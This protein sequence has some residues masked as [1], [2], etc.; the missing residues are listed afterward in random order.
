MQKP[1]VS[2]VPSAV[3]EPW[4]DTCRKTLHTHLAAVQHRLEG[5]ISQHQLDSGA[6]HKLRVATRRARTV[7]YIARCCLPSSVRKRLD[8]RLRA[9]AEIAGTVRDWDV[10]LSQL[11]H[12]PENRSLDFIAGYTAAARASALRHLLQSRP[13]DPDRVLR[14]IR[15]TF[16][17][18]QVPD[19]WQKI[20]VPDQAAEV[21]RKR[22][23]KLLAAAERYLQDRNLLHRVRVQGKRLRY[24]I[25]AFGDSIAAE[26]RVP[27]LG[28]LAELQE[29]LGVAN[30]CEVAL[31][32]LDRL[33]VEC[34]QL[35]PPLAEQYHAGFQRAQE[36]VRD[37]HQQHIQQ[38]Q[39]RWTAWE[40][41]IRRAF[42]Q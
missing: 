39:T 28:L 6:I 26:L 8:Q 2:A 22:V 10:F 5:V 32:K 35:S 33:E 12:E 15:E 37:Q 40:E 21:L 19:A 29:I 42:S 18:W 23:R 7:V 14:L 11:P 38:F 30:D 3:S 4:G 41:V 27:L 20:T 25:E 1:V 34:G 13:A 16:E 31:Q 36:H 17:H 9:I 24:A